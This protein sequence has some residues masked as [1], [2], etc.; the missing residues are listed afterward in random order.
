MEYLHNGFTI[1]TADGA[2]PISTDSMVLAHA[3]S[4]GKNARILDLGSGCGTLGLLLC[5]Q[6]PGCLVTGIEIDEN[7]HRCAVEN[8][9]RNGLSGRLESICADL[10][11]IPQIFPAGS[12]SACISNPPYFTAGP[13]SSLKQARR[14]DTCSMDELF[15][16]ADWAVQYGGDFHLVH[17]PERFA[18]LCATAAAHH[19]EVKQVLLL[20]HRPDGPIT[21]ILAKCRKGGKAGLVW[22]ENSL[23]NND[24]T[25]TEYYRQVYHL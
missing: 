2:F 10:R 16:A 24:G 4:P 11:T 18:Q 8:I 6:N 21:L 5:A 25:P 13:E 20:R 9:Q 3:A 12:F 17:R 14:E 7:A 19:F 23:Y 15:C 1:T 22:E